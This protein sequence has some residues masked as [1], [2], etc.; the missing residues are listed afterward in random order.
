[1]GHGRL[2]SILGT[3]LIPVI[4]FSPITRLQIPA[5]CWNFRKIYGVVPARRAT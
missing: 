3:Y 1:M 4:D 2:D 5:Q